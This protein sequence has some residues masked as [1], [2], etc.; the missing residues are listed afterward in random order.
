MKWLI[1]N[2]FIS[3]KLK[4]LAARRLITSCCPNDLLL[5]KTY[6]RYF[7]SSQTFRSTKHKLS[8]V[9]EISDLNMSGSVFDRITIYN[10]DVDILT[11]LGL[12]CPRSR[13]LSFSFRQRPSWLVSKL[14]GYKA[15]VSGRKQG[16]WKPRTVRT[17]TSYGGLFITECYFYAK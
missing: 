7:V 15:G 6:S 16:I 11:I 9:L 4:S 5:Q 3:S 8:F 1:S 2:E 10:Q 12:W 13:P 17:T 14:L